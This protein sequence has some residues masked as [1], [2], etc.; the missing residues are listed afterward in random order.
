MMS[1]DIPRDDRQTLEAYLDGAESD[2]H[3]RTAVR[4]AGAEHRTEMAPTLRRVAETSSASGAPSVA[5]E[6]LFALRRL[7]EPLDYF[8]AAADRHRENKWLAYNALLILGSDAE[9]PDVRE[10]L[11]SLRSETSDAHLLGAVAIAERVAY[12]DE[13][14]SALATVDERLSLVLDNF[15]TD[16]NP[17]TLEPG[18]ADAGTDPRAVW[19]QRKLRELSDED[20]DRCAQRVAGARPPMEVSEAAADA[21]RQF[22]AGFLSEAAAER[23]RAVRGEG[24]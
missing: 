23:F 12:L 17:I 9:R 20:P 13:Q 18:K 16:W 2:E 24:G 3:V 10:R 11:R 4:R 15:R 7:G 14:Y 1:D 8:L 19:A 6:A 5:S 22:L 21:Y